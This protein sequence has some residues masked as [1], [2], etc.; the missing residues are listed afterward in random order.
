MTMVI[1]YIDRMSKFQRVFLLLLST[2][3]FIRM[4]SIF[5]FERERKRKQLTRIP[6]K[7]KQTWRP[8]L[9]RSPQSHGNKFTD[10]TKR[11][12]NESVVLCK[13]HSRTTGLLC[14]CEST[15]AKSANAR[16]K[17]NQNSVSPPPPPS[18]P[19]DVNLIFLKSMTV[20]RTYFLPIWIN[21]FAIW[22]I[23]SVSEL[24]KC[25]CATV[26]SHK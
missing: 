2:K 5:Y 4:H 12:K 1:L 26:H 24:N 7:A 15:Q 10:R 16:R 17:T 19:H 22:L 18:V 6:K 23:S 21:S 3:W 9:R 11:E 14:K 25:K 13:T 8:V 20:F